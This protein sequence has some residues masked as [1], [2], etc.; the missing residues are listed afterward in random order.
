[1]GLDSI[2][3]DRS[4]VDYLKTDLFRLLAWQYRSNWRVLHIDGF[5]TGSCLPMHTG[6]QRYFFHYTTTPAHSSPEEIAEI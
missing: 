4:I 2:L 3:F 6:V 5:E 1:M